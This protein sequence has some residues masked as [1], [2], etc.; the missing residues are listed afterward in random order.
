MKKFAIAL[1]AVAAAVSAQAATI[2]YNFNNAL[3]PMEI[4]QTGSLG[5]FDSALG[6][7]TGISFTYGAGISGDITLTYN[8]QATG[9]VNIRG[10]TTSDIFF[11]ST[12]SVIN[13]LLN[14]VS[15]SYNTGFVNMAPGDTFVS[16]TLTD[17]GSATT[18][19]GI[20]AAMQAAGGG[21][22]DVSCE[23]LS[24]FGVTGGGGFSGGSQ[25]TFG[26][27]NASITY[28]Y[29]VAPPPPVPEPGSMALVGLALAGLGLTTRRRF[30]K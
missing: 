13:A 16:P 5:L 18:G 15:L 26:Q 17:S 24:G 30:V 9:N 8:A 23:S 14:P 1:A 22:F 10:T 3:G 12:N 19:V 7:L 29:T 21:S 4:S 20:S 27:C 6:T 11:S 28:E 25:N 2:S